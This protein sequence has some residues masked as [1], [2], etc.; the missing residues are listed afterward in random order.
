MTRQL[1]EL[2]PGGAMPKVVA[3]I[4]EVHQAIKNLMGLIVDLGQVEGKPK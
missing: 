2:D 4:H 3:E 1:E